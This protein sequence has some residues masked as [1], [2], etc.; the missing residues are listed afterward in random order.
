MDCGTQ[1]A[2]CL[3]ANWFA[4]NELVGPWLVDV[5]GRIQTDG[6]GGLI[7]KFVREYG[8]LIVGLLGLTFGFW[9]WCRYRE[10]ILHKRLEKYLRDSDARLVEGTAHIIDVI[11]RP[12]PG[13]Q[14]ED[15]LFI[16]ADL[17]TVLRERN[18]DNT[19]FALSVATSADLQLASAIDALKRRLSTAHAMTA[20]LHRQLLSAY[21]I[22]G[23]IAASGAKRGAGDELHSR[24]LSYFR[25]A[26][27]LPGHAS[28]VQL[29]ELEAHQLRKLG[30]AS[31]AEAYSEVMRLAKTIE[32]ERQRV[33]TTARAKRYLSEVTRASAPGH[34]QMMMRAETPNNPFYPG[35]IPMISSFEPLNGWERLEKADMHYYTALGA[36][37]L[38][39]VAIEHAQLNDAEAE[40]E[41][42]VSELSQRKWF[43]PRRY[44]RLRAR[45]LEGQRRV[46]QAR[47]G[48]YNLDWLP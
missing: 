27:G 32:D 14:L 36:N 6:F 40:Y 25:I 26:L 20:S 31:A 17:R 10:H 37:P 23:A 9:R 34:A 5:I 41:R 13:Q 39:F 38:R 24:A 46:E 47:G 2:L 12:G 19:T 11:Q 30:L 43:R 15:P 16:D 28:D 29:K 48:S 35:A 45:A 3:V 22:R 8:Q 4:E 44:R 18:W 7:A 1:D 42:I 33:L 21:T